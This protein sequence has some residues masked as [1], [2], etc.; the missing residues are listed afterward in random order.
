MLR[1]GGYFVYSS[2]EAY[3]LDEKNRRIWAEMSD[4]A[5]RM[6]WQIASKQDQTVIW[7][8]PSTNRCYLRRNIGTLPPMCDQGDDPDA[9]W[10]VPL[11]AC[12]TPYSKR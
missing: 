8:K 7:V 3:A 2:P 4:F 12:I 1:P 11:N 9:A 10:N 5:K 6:C